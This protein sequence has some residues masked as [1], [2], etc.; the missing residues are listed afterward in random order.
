MTM[1][2]SGSA[3]LANTGTDLVPWIVGGAVLLVIAGAALL[4][5]RRRQ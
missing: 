2:L 3:A 4:L 1:L 5:L